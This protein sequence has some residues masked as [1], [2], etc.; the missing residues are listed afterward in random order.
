[1]AIELPKFEKTYGVMLTAC[2]QLKG[3]T[4]KIKALCERKKPRVARYRSATGTAFVRS[5]L[6][7]KGGLYLHVDCVQGKVLS[8][9]PKVTHK[10]TEVLEI[11]E[12]V[13]G[14]EIEAGIIGRFEVPL[15]K[16]P[17]TGLVRALS[18]ER[19]ISDMSVKLKGA[20][21]SL[22]GTPIKNIYWDIQGKK[23][24][25]MVRVRMQAERVVNVDDK[26]LSESW[27]WIEEQFLLFVLG[28]RKDG[29][30]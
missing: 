2:G 18:T 4:S 7:N 20:A 24:K 26:Y 16:L 29:K 27:N 14:L 13:R 1:M 11:I 30:I 21:V 12:A 17:E 9:K 23:E 15:A 19:R 25:Q 5:R 10:K 22:T 28:R 8:T 6:V 3:R